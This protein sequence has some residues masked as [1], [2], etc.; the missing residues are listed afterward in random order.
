MT[1]AKTRLKSGYSSYRDEVGSIKKT[2]KK[3]V[4]IDVLTLVTTS[5]RTPKLMIKM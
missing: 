4:T 5:D 2:G 1:S 3:E